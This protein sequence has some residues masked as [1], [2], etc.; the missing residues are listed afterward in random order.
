MKIHYINSRIRFLIDCVASLAVSVLKILFLFIRQVNIL[1][2][3]ILFISYCSKDPE[4]IRSS[5]L[6]SHDFFNFW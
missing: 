6:Q 4:E 3:Y 2:S 1:K 5:K